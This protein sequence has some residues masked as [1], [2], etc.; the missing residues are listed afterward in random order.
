VPVDAKQRL[1]VLKFLAAENEANF[2]KIRTWRGHI[3]LE[4]AVDLGDSPGESNGAAADAA[5]RPAPPAMPASIDFVANLASHSLYTSY[6]REP[7]GEREP[8]THLFAQRS[9]VTPVHFLHLDPNGNVGK[10]EEQAT[11]P[12]LPVIGRVAYRE[13]THHAERLMSYSSVVDPQR[14]FWSSPL[15][16]YEALR[17]YATRLEETGDFPV[18][19]AKL[20]GDGPAV[21]FV[22]VGSGMH[23]HGS[24]RKPA[25]VV[26]Q[27]LEGSAAFNVTSRVQ[28]SGDGQTLEEAEV[29]YARVDGVFVPT[30]YHLRKFHRHGGVQLERKFVFVDQEVNKP[31]EPST[32]TFAHLGLQDGERVVDKLEGGLRIYKKGHLIDPNAPSGAAT[33]SKRRQGAPFSAAT[34]RFPLIILAL[35]GVIVVMSLYRRRRKGN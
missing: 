3:R 27:R 9:V 12:G 16:T 29:E 32:F 31:V 17:G 24:N 21:Y 23:G 2:R 11:V 7:A 30:T 14:F 26:T 10:L 20:E 19:I 8:G 4:D 28:A 25:R 34:S 33:N 6:V 22:T 5:E 18:T 1:E 35:V 15:P 13:E